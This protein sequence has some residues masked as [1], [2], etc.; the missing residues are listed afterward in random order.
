R[1]RAYRWVVLI[2]YLAGISDTLTGLLLVFFP[3]W[4]LHR[5]G[6]HRLP[7]PPVFVSFIGIFVL[8]VGLAYLFAG[9]LPWDAGGRSGWKTAWLLT[10]LTRSLVAAFLL[11]KIVT[12]QLE[13]G[14]IT[15]ALADGVLASIQWTGLRAGWLNHAE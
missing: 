1:I 9:S 7:E 4:T 14:W 13:A 10:A 11:W 6:L 15:V 5:M 3:L 12:G 2:T 8:S